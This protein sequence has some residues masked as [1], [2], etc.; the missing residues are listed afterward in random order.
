MTMM[1]TKALR[2]R[3]K[4]YDNEEDNKEFEENDNKEDEDN[5]QNIRSITFLES[6]AQAQLND[7]DD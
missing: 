7:D 5:Y 6:Q 1:K 2:P 3:T 4:I